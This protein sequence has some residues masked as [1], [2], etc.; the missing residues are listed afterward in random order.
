MNF[1]EMTQTKG[2]KNFMSKVYGIGASVVLVGAMFKIMH[3][4]G[5]GIM[6]VVG[7][8]TEAFIFLTSA[9]EPLHQEWD[10][11][12]VYPELAGMHDEIEDEEV[13]KSV[14]SKKSALEKFDELLNSA[15]ITPDLFEKLGNGLRSLNQTT[16]KLAD[17]SEAS[18]ATNN[19]VASFEKASSKVNEFADLYSQSAQ[20]LNQSASKLATTYEHNANTVESTLSKFS[21]TISNSGNSLATA[22]Q[23]LALVVNSEAETSKVN[24]KNYIEQL[25]IMAKNL[26]ALNAIYEMQL[27]GSNEYLENSKKMF[28]G[29]DEIMESMKNSVEDVKKYREEISKLGN[30]LAAMN[31]IYGNMLSAMNF[32]K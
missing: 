16:E 3:W 31:T 17:V 1:S 12:I 22:Y 2:W 14:S 24:A 32:N 26:T 6:I 23:N 7:L 28:S 11:S 18:A 29:M 19:Y 8:S 5:A 21:E 4:P 10:W 30:N 13:K 27:Q 20:A 25:Q 15:Q 9:F